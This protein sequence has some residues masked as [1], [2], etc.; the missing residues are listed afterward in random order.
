[1]VVETF[2]LGRSDEVYRRFS[3]RGRMTPDGLVYLDS[4]LDESAARCF[5]LM[6]TADP[7]LF[8]PW[9]AVWDDLVSFEVVPLR[10]KPA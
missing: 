1:M 5:Q 10:K 4:W 7:A 8:G 9:M 2:R 6:E 3:T